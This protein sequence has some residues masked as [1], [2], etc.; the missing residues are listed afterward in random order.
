MKMLPR[1][2]PHRTT[3]VGSTEC[4]CRVSDQRKHRIPAHLICF[5]LFFSLW[6]TRGWAQ[7]IDV[8]HLRLLTMMS[9]AVM[10]SDLTVPRV[11]PIAVPCAL[12]ALSQAGC[13]AHR[14]HP[15]PHLRRGADSLN[16][17]PSG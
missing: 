5:L 1:S 10:C 14:Q 4:P 11:T 13:V 12:Y 6:R 8:L 2:R 9:S 3:S 16:C 17:M 15:L 7:T